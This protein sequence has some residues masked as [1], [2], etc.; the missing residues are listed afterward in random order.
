M[1][2]EGNFVKKTWLK[3]SQILTILVEPDDTTSYIVIVSLSELFRW[4]KKQEIKFNNW[5]VVWNSYIEFI[6]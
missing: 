4:K 2:N 5:R 6:C 3:C 1:K